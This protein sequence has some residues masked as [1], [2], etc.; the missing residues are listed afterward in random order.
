[1]I[2]TS[3]ISNISFIITLSFLYSFIYQKQSRLNKNIQSSIMG[4]LFGLIALAGMLV[5][6][7]FSPGIIFDGRSIILSI[8]A[9]LGGPIVAILSA[10]MAAFYRL[11]LGGS[12]VYVGISVIFA[13]ALIGLLYR[14]LFDS[15]RTRKTIPLYIFGFVVHLVMMILM[16][17]LPEKSS[18]EVIR[19][20]TLPVLV[21]YPLATTII[22]KILID[23]E[24][25][26]HNQIALELSEQKFKS[27]FEAAN[28]GKSI[29]LPTGE[30]SVNKAFCEMLGY[31]TAE[32]QHKKW[33]EITPLEDVEKVEE[34]LIP[35]YNGQH[36]TLRIQKR[37][38]HKD[39]SHIWV[40]LSVAAQRNQK[41]EILYF[42]TTAVNINEQKQA[43]EE[44]RNL[45]NNLEKQ[46]AEKTRELKERLNDLER[47][48]EA[49]IQRE[50][51][52]NELKNE[53]KRLQEGGK[54]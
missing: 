23:R 44:I 4:I 27:V 49:T 47:F 19:S 31:T 20:M 48:H 9:Y 34:L 54:K 51:R 37:Y 35:V 41:G 42:I 1:M 7:R 32:L 46:I 28:V 16:L 14:Y 8:G 3:I 11:Y 18:E 12:G 6:L 17:F 38:I 36:D 10:L 21:F 2:F 50:L 40:D 24:N 33:Q 15:N 53:I 29:T 45:K 39:G 22:A 5:P 26:V 30:I 43:E 52:M 13:S 25:T